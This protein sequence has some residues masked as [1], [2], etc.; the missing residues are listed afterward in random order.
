M[1][2]RVRAG[3]L[4]LAGTFAAATGL[5]VAG[6]AGVKPGDRIARVE[7]GLLG[8]VVLKDQPSGMTMAE[9]MK[10][11]SVP[12]VSV[13]VI[14]EGVVEWARGYGV[15]EAG[16]STAV[17]AETMF[18]A[19]SISKPVA[20][21]GMLALVE[22]G[23]LKLD[24]D[25]NL[26]LKSW[27]LPDNDF[28]K[29][30]K[31]TLR[32]L[33]SHSA[34]TTVHGFRGYAEGEPVPTVVQILDGVK[35][36]NSAAVRVDLAPGSQWRYSGGGI[37]AMQLLMTD[38][39]GKTFPALMSELVLDRIGM[40]HSTYEQPLS[41][42]RVARAATGHRAT[43]EAIA[44]KRHT[45]PEMAAAGLW[46]TAADLA[47]FAV[48]LQRSNAGKSSKVLS[49]AMVNQMLTKQSGDYG[50]GVGLGGTGRA[51][52]FSHGGSNVGFKCILFA[53]VQTGQ[54]AVVMTNGDRGSQLAGEILR[55][56]SREYGWPD[57]KPLEILAVKV[58]PE[59]LKT[60]AGDYVAGGRISVTS[61]NGRLFVQ[62]PGGERTEAYAV[63]ATE[64]VLSTQNIRITF[65]RTSQGAVD[66]ITVTSPTGKTQGKRV[67]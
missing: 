59:I 56:I 9:R 38:V 26:K 37:T 66:E 54:G 22:Q 32:R 3:A 34:G 55:S 2:R 4:A 14:N 49:T 36:A 24:E 60:Y 15:A 7:S 5:L 43:G 45:Y 20:A 12:G 6:Q 8:P 11:Y 63:S 57:H 48:E 41:A 25:I 10:H 28:T 40:K 61:E 30:N 50:L 65:I 39:T 46:T 62:P 35:P 44:G 51:A 29:E 67:K 21:M 64:F 47:A 17:T 58:S 27:K 33:S 23:Q 18:Q 19:A 31:V 53:Y 16:G 42:A 13:A 52:T 1:S